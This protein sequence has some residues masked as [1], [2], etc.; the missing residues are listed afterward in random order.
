MNFLGS[1]HRQVHWPLGPHRQERL[2]R[3]QRLVLGR[4]ELHVHPVLSGGQKRREL[5][6][7][8]HVRHVQQSLKMPTIG[9]WFSVVEFKGELTCSGH[10]GRLG[11]EVRKLP[12]HSR[13]TFDTFPELSNT[14]Q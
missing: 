9:R 6:L 2:N 8:D 10:P 7:V 1:T 5:R 4:V 3:E 13:L 14:S 12:T 11:M